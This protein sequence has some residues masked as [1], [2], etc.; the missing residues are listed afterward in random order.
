MRKKSTTK[1]TN[2]RLTLEER[3]ALEARANELNVTMSDL[4]KQYVLAG[5]R[6]EAARG[7]IFEALQEFKEEI[8]ETRRD[9]ALLAEVLLAA[10]GKVSRDEAHKWA[11]ENIRPD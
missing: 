5:L 4:V 3:E 11:R 8:R 10:A 1:P 9:H 6:E 2:C 7:S